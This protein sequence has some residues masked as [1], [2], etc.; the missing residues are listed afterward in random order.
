MARV[1]GLSSTMRM[2]GDSTAPYGRTHGVA[3]ML[4]INDLSRMASRKG[5]CHPPWGVAYPLRQGLAGEDR[6]SVSDELV[7][8]GRLDLCAQALNRPLGLGG[9]EAHARERAEQQRALGS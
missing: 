4:P 6:Q 5:R 2:V 7:E 8:R 1:V 3:P 9:A